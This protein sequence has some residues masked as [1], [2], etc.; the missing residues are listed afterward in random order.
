MS[1]GVMM[2][3]VIRNR[4]YDRLGR[5]SASGAVEIGDGPPSLASFERGKLGSNNFDGCDRWFEKLIRFVAGHGDE[6]F[7]RV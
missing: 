7:T 1:V 6:K 2:Q 3:Q 4:V 5:L